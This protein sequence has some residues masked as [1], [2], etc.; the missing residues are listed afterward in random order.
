MLITITA[1]FIRKPFKILGGHPA[2]GGMCKFSKIL[3]LRIYHWQPVLPVLLEVTEKTPV[4]SPS[5]NEYRLSARHFKMNRCCITEAGNSA[6]RSVAKSY[7]LETFVPRGNAFWLLSIQLVKKDNLLKNQGPGP[8][9]MAQCLSVAVLSADPSSVPSTHVR[10]IKT[11][12][13]QSGF[14]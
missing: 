4:K 9:E 14:R 13:N 10:E 11:T 2:R 12:C 6:W 5:V 7:L 3:E 1:N 8:R